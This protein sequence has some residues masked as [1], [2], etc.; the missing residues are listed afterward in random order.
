M[1]YTQT[2]T[3]R[4]AAASCSGTFATGRTSDD[5]VELAGWDNN[6]RTEGI[7]ERDRGWTGITMKNLDYI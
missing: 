7:R 4:L 2:E 3:E 5:L 1:E 6:D